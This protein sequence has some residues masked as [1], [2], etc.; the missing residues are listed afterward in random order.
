MRVFIAIELEEEVKEKLAGLQSKAE[1]AADKGKFTAGSNFHLTLYFIGE[2]DSERIRQI[3]KVIDECAEHSAPFKLKLS[4]LGSFKKGNKLI[5][6]AGV[7]KDIIKLHELHR[8]ISVKLNEVEPSSQSGEY[9]PHITLGRQIVFS[10]DF[11]EWSQSQ[12]VPPVEF[13]VDKLSLMESTRLNGALIY[14]PIYVKPLC[15]SENE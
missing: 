9:T 10:Q 5:I 15:T 4:K 8:Q 14:R 1:A 12:S 3:R 7:E 6:W 13:K 11:E 2:A